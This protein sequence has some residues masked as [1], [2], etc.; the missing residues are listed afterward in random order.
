M[1]IERNARGSRNAGGFTSTVFRDSSCLFDCL[2]CGLR[3][4]FSHP[5]RE[6]LR[7][8]AL[9]IPGM[10]SSSGGQNGSQRMEEG[11][12]SDAI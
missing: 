1:A 10:V 4:E 8:H 12:R 11:D 5:T 7:K 9:M 2:N 6:D 3:T